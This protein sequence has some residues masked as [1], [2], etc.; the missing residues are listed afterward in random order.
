MRARRESLPVEAEIQESST[1]TPE[2][3]DPMRG[4]KSEELTQAARSS[5]GRGLAFL[6]MAVEGNGAWPSRRYESLELSGPWHLE[7][8]PFVPALGAM[9]L[10]VCTDPRAEALRSRTRAFL[11]RRMEYPGVWRYWPGLAPDLDDTAICSLAAGP[12]P[13]LL[14]GT[15][16]AHILSHRDGEGRFRTYMRAEDAPGDARN[17]V[18]SV[19][20]ANTL[21][22]LGDRPDTRGAQRW[23][24]NLIEDGRETGSFHYYPDPMDLYVALARTSCVARPLFARLRPTLARRIADRRDPGGG[25]GD[26]LRTAQ[27][28]SALDMLGEA[29]EET[30]RSSVERLI[31]SQRPQGGWSECLAWQG[32]AP[33]APP[34]AGFASEA[35]TTA[36]CIEALERFVILA[37]RCAPRP[38]RGRAQPRPS[39]HD[40]RNEAPGR[41]SDD[42]GHVS[43]R[44]HATQ[45]LALQRF[46]N[47]RQPRHLFGVPRRHQMVESGLMG[48]QCG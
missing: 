22:W 33:P 26:A 31:E 17:V 16:V 28:I 15:N 7:Y 34:S 8:P 41:A 20:N 30:I 11:L 36:C 35:L 12:H 37:T 14:F 1:L 3:E 40:P 5:V 24:E 18:D 46:E 48:D 9:A 23:L 27:A 43:R 10:E 42:P 32:P 39:G 19:V 13:W 6:D 4:R 38:A 21:A 25:F 2:L 44:H 45:I 47:M 29:L